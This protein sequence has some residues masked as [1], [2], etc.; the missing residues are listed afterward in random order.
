M[1]HGA[2]WRWPPYRGSQAGSPNLKEREDRDEGGGR[3]HER[4]EQAGERGRGAYRHMTGNE[5]IEVWSSSWASAKTCISMCCVSKEL[6]CTVPIYS[7][8]ALQ[9]GCCSCLALAA[10][11]CRRINPYNTI[12]LLEGWNTCSSMVSFT[13]SFSYNVSLS[14]FCNN[15]VIWM[16][17]ISA[18]KVIHLDRSV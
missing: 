12:I 11:M 8:H 13:V 4:P 3:E 18:L 9:S 7:S 14:C 10:F 2:L 16:P 6:L 15:G 17:S 5:V 1:E